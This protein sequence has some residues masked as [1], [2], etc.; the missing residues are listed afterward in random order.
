VACCLDDKPL[1]LKLSGAV[2][3]VNIAHALQESMISG[4]KI[5][6]DEAG[7]R[8]VSNGAGAALNGH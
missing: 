1:P 8:I 7:K 2:S 6:F 5:D 3:A 4:R